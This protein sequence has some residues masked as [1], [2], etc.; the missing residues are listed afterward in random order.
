MGCELVQCTT[1]FEAFPGTSIFCVTPPPRSIINI[2]F[3][4]PPYRYFHIPHFLNIGQPNMLEMLCAFSQIIDIFLSKACVDQS[5]RLQLKLKHTKF[6]HSF[7]SRKGG[8]IHLVQFNMKMSSGPLPPPP[9][10][11]KRNMWDPAPILQIWNEVSC[12]VVST[13][14][15]L[16]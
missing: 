7:L 9:P 6:D 1:H 2:F 8:W 11:T 3:R 10:F 15:V 12:P 4:G 5:K 14:K 16:Q 13:Y